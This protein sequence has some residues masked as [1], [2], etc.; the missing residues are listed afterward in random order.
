[1]NTRIHRNHSSCRFTMFHRSLAVVAVLSCCLEIQGVAS[2]ATYYLHTTAGSD[3][4][5]G[6]I[7]APWQTLAKVQSGATS[8]DV[9]VIQSAD[10]ATYAAPWPTQVS[11]RA[12][13]L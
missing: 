8:G 11:Y 1:M 4:N 7:G 3:S 13:V 5:P 12:S 9:I 10:A 6:T 2:A